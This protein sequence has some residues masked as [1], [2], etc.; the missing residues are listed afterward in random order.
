MDPPNRELTLA[1]GHGPAQ[2]QAGTSVR[3]TPTLQPAISGASLPT[4]RPVPAPEPPGPL[5][6]L[7]QDPALST[8]RLRPALE[9]PGP[10]SQPCQEL[11]PSNSRPTPDWDSWTHNHPTQNLALPHQWASTSPRMPQGSVASLLMTSQPCTKQGLATNQTGASQATHNRECNTTEG[12]T[13][14]T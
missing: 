7:A 8:S 10:C 14:P 3:T 9:H 2:Q 5:S 4:S 12:P 11:T 13:Q 1:L 6:H